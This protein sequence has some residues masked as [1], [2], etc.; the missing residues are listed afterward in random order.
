MKNHLMRKYVEG[1][2]EDQLDAINFWNFATIRGHTLTFVHVITFEKTKVCGQIKHYF[3]KATQ[4]DLKRQ[5]TRYGG[6]KY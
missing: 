5:H 2:R 3:R 4:C 6:N 1:N